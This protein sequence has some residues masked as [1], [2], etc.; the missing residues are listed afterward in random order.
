MVGVDDEQQLLYA[1]SRDRVIICHN[2]KHFRRLHQLFRQQGRPHGGIIVL[3]QDSPVPRIIIRAAMMLDW[4]GTLPEHRSQLFGWGD[5]QT[6][7]IHGHRLLG[8][9]EGEVRLALGQ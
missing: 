1:A 9:S 4:L 8:Y 6:L 7:L 2:G 5:L 3:P